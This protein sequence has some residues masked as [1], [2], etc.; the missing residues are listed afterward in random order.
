VSPLRFADAPL[1]FDRAPPLLGEHND[2]VLAELGL[3]D[4]M[5]ALKARGVI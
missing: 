5:A 4:E 1:R 2:E 3:S